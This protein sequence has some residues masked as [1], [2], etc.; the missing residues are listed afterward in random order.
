[1]MRGEGERKKKRKRKR[2]RRE[3]KV[4]PTSKRYGFYDFG[5]ELLILSMELHGFS[6]RYGFYDFGME[7]LNDFWLLRKLFVYP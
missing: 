2:R 4:E 5:M 6:K 1:M 3:E 7:L